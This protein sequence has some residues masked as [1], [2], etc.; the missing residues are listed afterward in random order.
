MERPIA[1][2][3]QEH[4]LPVENSLTIPKKRSGGGVIWLIL[5][6]VALVGLIAFGALPRINQRRELEKHTKEQGALAMSVSVIAAQPGA[7]MQEFSLPGNTEAIQDAPIYSRVDG[8]LHKR[9]VNIG[10]TVKAGQVLADIETPEL[11]QQVLAA[12]SS[13]EQANANLDTARQNYLKSQVDE[14]S[15]AANVQK[16]KTDLQFYTRELARYRQLVAQGAVSAEDSDARLQAYNA[17]MANLDSMVA[18][19]RSAQ[20]SITSAKAA[21][22]VA[23]AAA[24][25]AQSLHDQY[26]ATQSFKKVTAL[27]D[28]VVTKRNVDAGALIASGSS[29][30]NNLLFEIAKTDVLRVFVYVPEQ[31]V[32]YVEDKEH[33][34]LDFQEFPTTHFDG[35]VTNVSGGI[36]PQSKTLQVEIHV[37]NAN[38]KLLPGM[39]AQVRF[40]VPTK[41][42]LPVVP[43]TT[44]QTRPDGAFMF[45]VDKAH[46]AHLHKVFVGRD[47]GGQFEIASGINV[48][49][50]VIIN[51]S[52]EIRDDMLVTPTVVDLPKPDKK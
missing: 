16:A 38:H 19:E 44:L 24:N 22:H 15:A 51:P 25:A 17:G 52:D 29:N 27:F 7:A 26:Q 8:Y 30:N 42:R 21:V 2:P 39:Y 1:N 34:I 33:A 48:G 36:D 5:G 20:V 47:L 40:Q 11:D 31:Y 28:G 45:V 49:D 50:L 4:N 37:P 6:I 9:Y 3:P 43:A 13:A 14:K 12:A 18:A 35:I 46:H 10:D 32:E 23:Q 41:I